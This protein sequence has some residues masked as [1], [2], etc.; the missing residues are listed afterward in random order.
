[1]RYP[2]FRE[3]YEARD[4]A[5]PEEFRPAEQERI[6]AH[7]RARG[8]S[9][10]TVACGNR[11]HTFPLP[12]PQSAGAALLSERQFFDVAP[13]LREA[14]EVA[15]PKCGH[16]QRANVYLFFGFLTAQGVRVVLGV[17]IGGMLALAIWWGLLR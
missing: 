12:E 16:K 8:M 15:C 6:R 10:E 13:E 9:I 4:A 14:E 2:G 11:G 7:V 1:M 3:G 5:S 17:S